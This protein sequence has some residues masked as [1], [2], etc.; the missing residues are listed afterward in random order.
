[1]SPSFAQDRT[2]S[3]EPSLND[4]VPQVEFQRWRERSRDEFNAVYEQF[5]PSP[6]RTEYTEN[7]T[8]KVEAHVPLVNGPVPTVI[9]LHYWGASDLN[10]ERNLAKR[11]NQRGVAAVIMPLPYHLTRT[12]RGTWSGQLAV[13]A[14]PAKFRLMMVQSVQDVRRSLDWIEQEPALDGN[15]VGIGGVSLGS[16]VAALAF[17][18]EPRIDSLST[19]L[20]GADFAHIIWNSSRVVLQREELRRD[21][22]SEESL[23]EA[24][25]PVEPLGYLKPDDTRPSLVIHGRHDTVVPPE[26]TDKLATALGNPQ[27]ITLDTGHFGGVLVQGRLLQTIAQFF[28]ASFKGESF[29][30][31]SSIYAPAL[32]LGLS[33]DG[34]AGLQVA[35]G[36]DVWRSGDDRWFGSVMLAPRGPFGYIG[37]RMTEEL[38]FGATINRKATTWGVMY[39]VIL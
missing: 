25:V 36:L 14:D 16:L 19:L 6:V 3:Q 26:D 5:F 22:Y 30:A 13:Q 29:S 11:L 27:R 34:E 31:P 4:A 7:N 39:S 33:M 12:P 28:S 9:L 2:P 21:G 15:R 32:R 20:G 37:Y 18:V 24:L 35:G 8:I 17:S 10:L 38:S 1:M 23:R